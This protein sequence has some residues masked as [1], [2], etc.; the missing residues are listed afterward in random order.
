MTVPNPEQKAKELKEL[1]EETATALGGTNQSY[2][3]L[4]K[5]LSQQ[6]SLKVPG[7]FLPGQMVFFKY[8][9]QTDRFIA[10]DK[11][12]DIFPLV[13]ITDV[14]RDGFEGINI[15][16]LS[17]KW[18]KELFQAVERFL[19]KRISGDPSLTR[20]GTT[21]ARLGGSRKFK[22]F[23]PCYRRYVRSGFRKRPILIP[24]EFWEVMVDVDLA[25]FAKGPK[26]TI[27][28]MTY[29][30]AIRSENNP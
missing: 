5:Y 18:R 26:Q 12:Y 10:S 9:P 13:I 24:A 27:R 16:F 7:V 30:S 15:H 3:Q 11:P 25:L 22:F 19:P 29:N 21:Y 6:N 8:K 1:L 17:S 14:H 4:L 20:L 28:R 23:R 2:I